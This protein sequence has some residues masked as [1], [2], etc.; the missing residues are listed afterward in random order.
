MQTPLQRA[1]IAPTPA[2]MPTLHTAQA[3][4]IEGP[5][6]I[7]FAHGQ[8][9]SLVSTLPTGRWQF[10]SWLD[11]QGRVRHLFHLARISDE[12]LLVILRGGKATDF[13]ESLR[14]YV[15]RSRVKLFQTEAPLAG[16]PSLPLHD[17]HEQGGVIAFGC[18]THTLLFGANVTSD[19]MWRREQLRMG[20]P[21]LPDTVRDD[22]LPPALSLHR[23][24]A[25]A[26]DKGCYPG[27][28]IVA[29]LHY[30]GGNKR[31]L[32]HVRLSKHAE[33][34]TL[35]QRNGREFMRLLNVVPVNGHVEALVVMTDDIASQLMGP[36][37][38]I[39]DEG[40]SILQILNTW[41]D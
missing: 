35:L 32:H 24:H 13:I 31:H 17:I 15:F 16:G 6:A 27:Q 5:D 38:I 20:W 11:A 8:F 10:S 14:R 23:L 25:V 26:L 7:A 29:R 9:A 28:E 19:D 39:S 37:E 22:L 1:P 30:R 40:M 12:R 41:R 21:W 4:F 3:I 33:E 18:E 34:G 36:Q 2:R